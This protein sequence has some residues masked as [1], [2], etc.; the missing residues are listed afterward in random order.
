MLC[1]NTT[2]K[3]TISILVLI[4]GV[5]SFVFGLLGFLIGQPEEH[6][7]NTLLGMFTGFGFGIG[8]VAVFQLIRKRVTP[9]EKLEQEQIEREDER[10]RA[11]NASAASVGYMTA[12]VLLAAFSFLFMGMG[13]RL[14]SYVCILGIYVLVASYAI[15]R[16]VLAKRM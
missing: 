8:A 9:K 3:N 11:L 10:N 2:W 5:V 1:K 7:L 13:N 16:R 4:L 12:V 14:P 6:H 15:A